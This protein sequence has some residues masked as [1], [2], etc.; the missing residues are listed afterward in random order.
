MVLL[1]GEII[2]GNDNITFQHVYIFA[3]VKLFGMPLNF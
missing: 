2:S 1:L 3:V